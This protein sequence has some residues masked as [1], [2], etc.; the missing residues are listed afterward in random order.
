MELR[1][2]QMKDDLLPENSCQ[3]DIDHFSVETD[4]RGSV[5]MNNTNTTKN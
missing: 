3:E 4:V 5:D 1:S 2:V